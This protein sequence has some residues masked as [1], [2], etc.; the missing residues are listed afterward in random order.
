MQSMGYFEY[1]RWKRSLSFRCL[2]H[3]GRWL[4]VLVESNG[5]ASEAGAAGGRCHDNLGYQI[6]GLRCWAHPRWDGTVSTPGRSDGA[7]RRRG[8]SLPSQVLL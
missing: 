3:L 7:D 4:T 6:V 1:T 2:F 8:L 5:R